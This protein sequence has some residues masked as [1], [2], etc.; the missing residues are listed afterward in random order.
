[1][2]IVFADTYYFLAL[3]SPSDSG[4]AKAVAFTEGFLGRIVTTEWVL[5]E[6]ANA[7]SRT[8]VGQAEF[9][10]TRV[11]LQAD[12]MAIIIPFGQD[13]MEE[14]IELYGQRSDKEWSLT[15]CISFVVMRREAIGEAL[16]ADHHFEQAGFTILLK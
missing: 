15:D 5:T 12:P 4:H 16:T 8:P 1:M 14:G 7:L 2:R 11:D 13:L 9:V 6:L 10:S 3:L